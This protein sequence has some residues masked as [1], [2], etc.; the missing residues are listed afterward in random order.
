MT[1]EFPCSCE[2]FWSH[3]RLADMGGQPTPTNT[4]QQQL[5]LPLALQFALITALLLCLGT[6]AYAYFLNVTDPNPHMRVKLVL[7]IQVVF[8]RGWKLLL[9]MI[10]GYLVGTALMSLLARFLWNRRTDRLNR[11]AS[12]P[13][14]QLLSATDASI[15]PPPPATPEGQ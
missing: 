15:W 3:F 10:V 5:S 1:P 7:F 6:L 2:P 14:P 13:Q 9:T 11:E 12:L 4:K 8:H